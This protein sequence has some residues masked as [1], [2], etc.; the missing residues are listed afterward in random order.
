MRLS[1][2]E[3]FLEPSRVRGIQ[4]FG[5]LLVRELQDNFGVKIVKTNPDINLSVIQ[6]PRSLGAKNVI[7]L[8][9]VYYDVARLK[10]NNSIKSSLRKADGI[11]YQSEW[12]KI[13]VERMLRSVPRESAVVYNGAKT[14]LYTA[15]AKNKRGFDKVVLCCA[16]WRSN[17][18]LKSIVKSF[19]RCRDRTKTNLGLFVIGKPDYT[20]DDASVKFF[21]TVTEEIYSL[22]ASADYMCHICHL[23]A[24]PNSVVEG[25]CAG[26]P[27]LCNN[28]GGTPE[29]VKTD[30]VV[31]NLD[32]QFNFSPVASMKAV[33]KVDIDILT[34]GMVE[35][36]S[37]EWN[38][39]R[40]DLDISVSAAGY[41][42]FFVELL[43]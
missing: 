10:M 42:D 16:N 15:A 7:R 5:L 30:G 34:D 19:L 8:D 26:L 25:L 38:V 14:S 4:K 31:A 28:I 22:Y 12:S 3:K 9:G 17:K 23:D 2:S 35:M 40:A 1:L 24:C 39:S 27:V 33:S 6:G 32:V 18:R 41:H 43:S 37:R 13:F 21:G 36:V 29:L 11:I 20:C